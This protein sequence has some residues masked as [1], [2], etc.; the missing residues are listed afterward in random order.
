MTRADKETELYIRDQLA[1]HFP[2]HGILG[3]EF[4]EVNADSEYTWII[5]PI[6][7]THSFMH[8]IPLYGI[9]VCLMRG[10]D[11]LI[12]VIDLPAIDRRYSAAKGHGATCNGAPIRI[13]DLESPDDIAYQVIGTGERRSFLSCGKEGVFDRMIKEHAHVRTYCD[14]FGH[15]LAAQG[16][17]GV[18]LDFNV[19]LWDCAS[20]ILL[21]EEAGGKAVCVGQRMDGDYMRYDWVF[22]KPSMVDWVI[23]SFAG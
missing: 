10:D 18:M 3:E 11:R 20:S 6:D 15:A 8:N 21:V 1:A 9:L 4:P 2:D 16:V 23:D 19:R 12:S 13:V 17:L 5:D 22:G 7:G 14:C